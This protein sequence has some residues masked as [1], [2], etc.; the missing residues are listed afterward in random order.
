MKTTD[1]SSRYNRLKLLR[2]RRFHPNGV[3]IKDTQLYSSTEESLGDTGPPRMENRGRDTNY[4]YL[5]FSY[6][7]FNCL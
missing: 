4:A 1:C 5:N 6:N 3:R 7:F 2:T